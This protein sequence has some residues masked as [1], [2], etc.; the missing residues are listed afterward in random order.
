[1]F[2]EVDVSEERFWRAEPK[3]HFM[4]KAWTQSFYKPP[5]GPGSASGTRWSCVSGGLHQLSP[6]LTLILLTDDP[7]QL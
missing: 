4:T 1:M 7:E 6:I 5:V 2:V 3:V